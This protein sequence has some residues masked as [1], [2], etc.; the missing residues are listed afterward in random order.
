MKWNETNANKKRRRMCEIDT[1]EC[2]GQEDQKRTE[3][4]VNQG[5]KGI[6]RVCKCKRDI[7]KADEKTKKRTFCPF[8][9]FNRKW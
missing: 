6:H 3:P 9:T 8:F 1:R 2:A 7:E 5:E 4:S